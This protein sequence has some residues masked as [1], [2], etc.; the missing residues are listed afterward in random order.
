MYRLSALNNHQF[1]IVLLHFFWRKLKDHNCFEC[2]YFVKNI[3][4]EWHSWL[5]ISML[6]F[7]QDINHN[8][9]TSHGKL[10]DIWFV[11]LSV[12]FHLKSRTNGKHCLD[13][14][15]ENTTNILINYKYKHNFTLFSL[16][17][18]HEVFEWKHY[19]YSMLILS[20]VRYFRN[21]VA[22]ILL[23]LP[24]FH[25]YKQAILHPRSVLFP[26]LRTNPREMY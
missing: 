11:F 14:E 7:R 24:H 23:L 15:K 9:R 25:N 2:Q 16:L 17:K 12:W 5:N 19:N 3:K 26:V 10:K 18:H 22:H 21:L 13:F 20:K 4:R 1:R 8:S 6:I